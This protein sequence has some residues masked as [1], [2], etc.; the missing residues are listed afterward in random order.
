M[1]FRA[2]LWLFVIVSGAL[3]ELSAGHTFWMLSLLTTHIPLIKWV[4]A[5]LLQ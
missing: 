4:D 5:H 2:L 3:T 1:R